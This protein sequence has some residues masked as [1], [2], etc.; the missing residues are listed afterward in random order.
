VIADLS[1]DFDFWSRE[2]VAWDWGHREDKEGMFAG[3]AW[4]TRYWSQD[5]HR[6]CSFRHADFHPRHLLRELR[7]RGTTFGP[8]MLGVADS[9]AHAYTF[10]TRRWRD[11]G[12]PGL[13]IQLDAHHDCWPRGRALHCG[14]WVTRLKWT[15]PQMRMAQV[16][17]R[18]KDLTLDGRPVCAIDSSKWEDT[19]PALWQVQ[20][21]HIF[22]C[23]SPVWVPPHHDDEFG[24]LVNRL[25]RGRKGEQFG[26]MFRR[27]LPSYRELQ[28][29][30]RTHREALR[31]ALHRD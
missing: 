6:E 8:G 19:D 13:V 2:E 7:A 4:L 1:I 26:T 22:L 20:V 30:R 31:H 10:F 17:P 16:Y 29:Q 18:W 5:L 14:N 23:R 3:L 11:D 21:R 27:A 28:A 9:H 25:A 12:L 15:F 24:R